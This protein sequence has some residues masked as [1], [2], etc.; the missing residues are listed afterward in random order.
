MSIKIYK[1]LVVDDSR[2][3]RSYYINMLKSLSNIEFIQAAD[4][5]MALQEIEASEPDCMILDNLMPDKTG[6]EVLEEL[7]KMQIK[8]PTIFLTA[9]TQKTTK[10]RCLELGAIA[11]LNKPVEKEVLVEMVNNALQI[12]K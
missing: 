5:N 11:F 8:I 10:A 2:V 6:I 3:S 9:D 7:N 1:I 12:K 4:G